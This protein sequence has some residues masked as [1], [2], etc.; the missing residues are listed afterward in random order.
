MYQPTSSPSF[1]RPL[2][3][4]NIALVLGFSVLLIGAILFWVHQTVKQKN[5]EK[6]VEHLQLEHHDVLHSLSHGMHEFILVVTAMKSFIEQSEAIP[7]AESLQAFI[8]NQVSGIGLESEMVVSYLDTNHVIQYSFT[9]EAID[10][11][12]L[13]GKNLRDFRDE[14]TM[15]Q[16]EEVLNQDKLMFSTPLNMEEGF[17]GLPLYSR[18]Q[19]GGRTIGYVAPVINL[20]DILDRSY[21]FSTSADFVFRFQA[22]GFDL[23]REQIH[24]GKPVYHQRKDPEFY[25]NYDLSEDQFFTTNYEVFGMPFQLSTAYKQP[26]RDNLLFDV[27]L[28]ISGLL[29][30]AVVTLCLYEFNRYR[31]TNQLIE[32]KN[33]VLSQQNQQLNRQKEALNTLLETRN[34]LLGIIAHDIRSPLAAQVSYFTHASRTPGMPYE[35][36]AALDFSKD[37]SENVLKLLDNLLAWSSLQTGAMRPDIQSFRLSDHIEEVFALSQKSA[38]Q[39]NIQLHTD[40]PSQTMVLGDEK[41]SS[42]IVRNLITNA[43]KF[44]ENG[45]KIWVKAREMGNRI[46]I[47]VKDEGI[48]ISPEIL[49][50][51]F[52]PGQDTVRFGTAKEKGTGLGLLLCKDFAEAQG[53]ELTVSSTPGVGSTFTFWL[54]Q[55][56][57]SN[58]W[59]TKN[60]HLLLDQVMERS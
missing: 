34:L 43:I 6:R 18:V 37:S 57:P 29:L 59:K 28:V 27:L 19:K 13:K 36:Q 42:T 25:Q 16:L 23:D 51:L 53:G 21:N 2:H 52:T 9:R 17:V 30:L 39:K 26:Y 49:D 12:Q 50:K 22:G 15:Q 40:V 31:K 20:K 55:C 35:V 14:A 33:E 60:E 8:N 5:L 1:G 48:G 38:E 45:K 3:S 4:R 46:Y 56:P 24:N 32:E 11:R 7:S 10:P 41:M 58:G 54:P 47:S 44:S